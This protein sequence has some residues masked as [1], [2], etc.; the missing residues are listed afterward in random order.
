MKLICGY[1]VKTSNNGIGL[2]A[3]ETKIVNRTGKVEQ[4]SPNERHH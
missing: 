2:G 1:T 4:H 3:N